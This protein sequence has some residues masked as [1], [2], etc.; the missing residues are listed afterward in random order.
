M[1]KCRDRAV[2][3]AVQREVPMHGTIFP[4][5]TR[6]RVKARSGVQEHMSPAF[7]DVEQPLPPLLCSPQGEGWDAK[8][9]V[10]SAVPAQHGAASHD[11]PY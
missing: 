10:L 2:R 9:P 1:S 11:E 8:K 3:A 4:P 5:K 6:S 7:H